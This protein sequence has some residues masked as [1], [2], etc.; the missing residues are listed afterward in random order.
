MAR[1]IILIYNQ[2]IE[3]HKYKQP[4]TTKEEEQKK[5][6]KFPDPPPEK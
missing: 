4:T 3:Y 2:K 1:G 5:P 6:T